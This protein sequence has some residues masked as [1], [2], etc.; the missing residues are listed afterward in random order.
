MNITCSQQRSGIE[1]SELSGA[2]VESTAELG[3]FLWLCFGHNKID[4]PEWSAL[5]SQMEGAV[6]QTLRRRSWSNTS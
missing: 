6:S 4:Q 5:S 2:W 1:D 3:N